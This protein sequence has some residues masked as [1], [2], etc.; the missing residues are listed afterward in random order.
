MAQNVFEAQVETF[1]GE[2]QLYKV[3]FLNDDWTAMDFVV[4]VLMEV[5][6]K[7]S[8]EAASITL[9][10]H[11]EGMGLAGV[12]PYDIAELKIHITNEKAR[13]CKYPLRVIMEKVQS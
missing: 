13:E 2:P 8:D 4:S 11:N 1:L 6:D 7:T 12:Y 5:F 10:I 9:I 3:L